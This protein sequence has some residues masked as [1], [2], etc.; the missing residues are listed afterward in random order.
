M[1]FV[2]IN[3]RSKKIIQGMMCVCNGSLNNSG[4]PINPPMVERMART[5]KGI[6]IVEGDSC[7]CS[8]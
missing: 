2:K 3:C 4:N 1:F 8:F 7:K 6:V 5:I